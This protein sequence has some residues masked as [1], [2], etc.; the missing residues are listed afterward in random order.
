ML[1]ICNEA[2]FLFHFQIFSL[3]SSVIPI[4]QSD[5]SQKHMPDH[6]LTCLCSQL[7]ES[8]VSVLYTCSK[9]CCIFRG[10][11]WIHWQSFGGHLK[12]QRSRGYHHIKNSRPW[13]NNLGQCFTKVIFIFWSI[14][15]VFTV[16][17]VICNTIQS[18]HHR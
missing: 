16:N 7:C 3:W 18:Q 13:K 15:P 4:V 8:P 2:K 9:G 17:V 12:T 10:R 11:N 1:L 14:Y 6:T 5:W